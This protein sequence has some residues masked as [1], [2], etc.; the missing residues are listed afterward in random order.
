M[1]P[2][3]EDGFVKALSGVTTLEEVLRVTR[4]S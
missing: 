3:I 2:M 4:E 1:R